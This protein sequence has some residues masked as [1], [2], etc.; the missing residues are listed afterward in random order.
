M[1]R[2][3]SAARGLLGVVDAFGWIAAA[4]GVLI[5]ILV[6]VEH[7]GGFTGGLLAGGPFLIGGIVMIS[8]VQIARAQLD[9]AENSAELVAVMSRVEA[10]LNAAASSRL[11]IARPEDEAPAPL[12]HPVRNA[13]L[14]GRI[15]RS[16]FGKF[17]ADGQQ[18]DAA[19][20]AYRHLERRSQ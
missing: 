12:P 16:K 1:K 11:S 2:E 4:G 20:D 17:V 18:F 15:T 5:G 3:Y 10:A 14:D 19:E 13:L 7:G 9:T 8:M 6:A